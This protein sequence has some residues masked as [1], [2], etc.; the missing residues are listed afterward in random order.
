MEGELD[1]QVKKGEGTRGAAQG[2]KDLCRWGRRACQEQGKC[3]PDSRVLAIELVPL[4]G[5]THAGGG[6]HLG[7]G[8]KHYTE[9]RKPRA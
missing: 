2:L 1:G 3:W 7:S 5:M 8:E 6:G 4:E 9:V